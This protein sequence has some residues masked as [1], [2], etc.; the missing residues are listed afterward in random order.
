MP[1]QTQPQVTQVHIDPYSFLAEIQVLSGNPVQNYNKDTNEYEPDRSLIPCVLMPYISV[2]DPEGLM[3]GS[4]AITGA[5]WYE[6]APKA[7]GSN[8]IVNN[9]DYAIS[10]T[11]KP[12]YSLTVRKNIDYNSP[13]E[14]Y[15]IFSITD[16]RKNT[17]EKFERSIPFR[18]TLF[19]SN[20]YSLKINRP[21]G[22]TINPLEVTPN[23][24]GEWL[25]DITAQVY[26]GEDK[27]ADTNAAYWWQ[28]L[29]GTAW[30]DFTDD[31]LEICVSGKNAN[32][33][34]GRTLTL[35]ARFFR[36]IS[37]R[38]R[39]AYYTGARPSSPTS[40]EMQATTSIKV[41]M[42]GTLRADIRQTK[43][44]K[45]TSRMNTPVGYECILSY[46]KQLIGTNKDDL[47]IIDWHAKSAKPGS[48][49]VNVGRGRTVEFIPS[50]YSFDP[51]YPISVYASIRMYAV[52]AL[53]TNAENKVLS[54]SDGKLVIISKYE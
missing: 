16:K 11:G 42:P 7:N 6:G 44:V 30:R 15:C 35:D 38:V 31:E 53:V 2:M 40:D 46:N 52:T 17:Q 49:A 48:D 37:V 23:S 8:R 20:N 21:K 28:V 4:Q 24:K 3:N 26:S 47:F 22:W 27:V 54:M 50:N 10:A 29:D 36:N 18:T 19:D 41:E 25:F 13:V 32:G 51:L 5:E 45:L 33:T 14:I 39:G 43:G 34:W 12:A 1:I 9:D